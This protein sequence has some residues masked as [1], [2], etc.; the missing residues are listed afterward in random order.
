MTRFPPVVDE[1]TATDAFEKLVGGVSRAQHL[2]RLWKE[3]YPAGRLGW[4]KGKTKE[5]VFR[6]KAK[7]D[8]F[9]VKEINAFLRL[10]G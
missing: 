6:Q 1:Q 5:E 7:R 10:A 4:D 3:S 8:G 2:F 9:V